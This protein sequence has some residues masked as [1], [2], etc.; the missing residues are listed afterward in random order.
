MNKMKKITSIIISLSVLI[1]AF[2][3][4]FL[5]SAKGVTVKT[6]LYHLV[7]VA[8]GKYLSLA[9]NS[10]KSGANIRSET[11][12]K[13]AVNQ[14]IKI[15]R[16]SG[17]SYKI[18]PAESTDK[19]I[20]S[21]S[22]AK[23][24]LN[25]S[26]RNE[27]TSNTQ[28]WYFE[29]VSNGIYTIRTAGNYSI[30]LTAEGTKPKS[31]VGLESYSK[32]NKSQQWK[33]VDFSLRKEGDDPK[34]LS[35]GIDVSKWQGEI[36]WKAVREYGV[37]FAIIRIGYSEVKDPYFEQ[38][39][40]EAVKNGIKV[41]VYLYS[42]NVNVAQA[43]RDANDVLSWLSGKSLQ[44][45]IFYDIEDAEYQGS[46]S[47]KLRTDMCL[48]FMEKI[49]AAGYETGVYA[50][51]NWF[52]NKLDLPT[53]RQN[54]DMWLAKWPKSDQADEDNSDYQ[55][56]QFR[57]DG[58]VAGIGGRVD[59]NVSYKGYNNYTYSGKPI[60]PVFPA[61]YEGNALVLNRDYVVNYENN[62]NAG[63]AIA[64]ISGVG[65]YEG[66]F[67]F[68]E[69][70]RINPVKKGISAKLSTTLYTYNGKVKTPAVTVKASNGKILKK[71]TDY[72][73]T[74]AS[75]R[76]YVGKYKVTVRLKGNYS[77]TKT[78]YLTIKPPKTSIKKV[79]R[80]AR[81][82]LRIYFTKKTQQISGYQVQYS[83]Y[84]SF[85]KTKTKTLRSYRYTNHTF[86]KL[87]TRK[88]YYVRVR[89]YKSAGGRYYYSD[90]STV[91]RIKTT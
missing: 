90:W 17:N 11:Y 8:S 76:K 28:C 64:H 45:P 43:K 33:L 29:E 80:P 5:V 77:G 3:S 73:V 44:L 23:S 65:E 32:D 34:I 54:G 85:K 27:S 81:R 2:S 37:D 7:N 6:G 83:R 91:K 62:V 31:N 20:G 79:T 52:D 50:N 72:T 69:T 4:A 40:A 46:L 59:M 61:K 49:K 51:Q 84:K 42:Y 19:F 66:K 24:G 9:D 13:D 30:A 55:L 12:V 39:Y 35:Y 87:S 21:A 16:G 47:T 60:T 89:T 10:D 63:L 38:N 58:K 57:S 36:N 75:G 14:V 15:K 48:A 82:K 41:G 56:W 22:A 88:Y 67:N 26:L 70:F 18:Q 86:T 74:Y 78:L 68:K 25:V 71:N 53:L 1:T